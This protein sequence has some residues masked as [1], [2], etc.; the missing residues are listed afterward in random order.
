VENVL[1]ADGAGTYFV[2]AFADTDKVQMY[3]LWI[4]AS[5][6]QAP[7]AACKDVR[8]CQPSVDA[9]R[10]NNGSY[11][12]DGDAITLT[13]V[14]EAPFPVG[15]SEVTLIVSDGYNADSCQA[16]VTVNTPPTAVAQNLTVAGDT[17]ASCQ[18]AVAGVGLDNGS[19]DPD[20]TRWRS[21]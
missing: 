14:P 12:P 7:V 18:A 1:L 19:F 20:G 15:V 10:V 9:L 13:L 3:E 17:L 2:K 5:A 11:D 8:S 21:P 16:M 4:T 6:G